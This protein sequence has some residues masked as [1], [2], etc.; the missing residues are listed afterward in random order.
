MSIIIEG[1][2]G[3]GKS[4]LIEKLVEL[5]GCPSRHKGGPP[6]SFEEARERMHVLFTED[7]GKI[8]DRCVLISEPI[9]GSILRNQSFITPRDFKEG[10]ERLKTDAWAIVYCCTEEDPV[11]TYSKPW[12][13]V[14]F[15]KTV[16]NNLP[17]IRQM[18][19]NVFNE[20]LMMGK[21]VF[22]YDWK[23]GLTPEDVYMHLKNW[24]YFKGE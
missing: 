13:P 11:P 19:R 4:T 2:D 21:T 22:I 15:A 17:A 3:S 7:Y 12:K 10:I 20:I 23:Q 6:K 14:E 9:Y 24:A 16:E 18:Y 1:P 5:S 8:C